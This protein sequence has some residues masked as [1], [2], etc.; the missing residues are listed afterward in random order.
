MNIKLQQFTL[1]EFYI[2]KLIVYGTRR[3]IRTPDHLLKR[4]LLYQAELCAHENNVSIVDKNLYTVNTK[5]PKKVN[6]VII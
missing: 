1:L 3:G 5:S 6:S 4:Q 2:F